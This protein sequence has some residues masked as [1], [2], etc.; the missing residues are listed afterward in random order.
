MSKL[1]KLTLTQQKSVKRGSSGFAVSPGIS[2]TVLTSSDSQPQARDIEQPFLKAINAD[3][4]NGSLSS[5]D[6]KIEKA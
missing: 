1:W 6:F 2:F 5:S 3:S 4:I